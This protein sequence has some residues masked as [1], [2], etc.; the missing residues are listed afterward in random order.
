MK[1]K[2]LI[3]NLI[4]DYYC[5]LALLSIINY[6]KIVYVI[7]AEKLPK[8]HD[9]YFSYSFFPYSV[10]CSQTTYFH[11]IFMHSTL[12]SVIYIPFTSIYFQ[13]I[14]CG[15]VIG[16]LWMTTFL[17]ISEKVEQCKSVKLVSMLKNETLSSSVITMTN[18]LT[19]N[20]KQN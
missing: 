1:P 17:H 4:S 11:C 20:L 10:L 7:I 3:H 6:M 12:Q 8:L 2:S 14:K 18:F 5:Q 15:L 13:Q 9:K 16:W 19:N